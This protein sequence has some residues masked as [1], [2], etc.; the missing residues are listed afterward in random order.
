MFATADAEVVHL[1]GGRKETAAGHAQRR[2]TF[3]RCQLVVDVH[4]TDPRCYRLRGWCCQVCN[5]ECVVSM[6]AVCVS[7]KTCVVCSLRCPTL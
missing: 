1:Q 7:F 6:S 4:T 2:S 5:E 3:H